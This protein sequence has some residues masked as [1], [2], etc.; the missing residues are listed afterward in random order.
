[1]ENVKIKYVAVT[2]LKSH[3]RNPRKHSKK[4]VRQIGRSIKRFGFVGVIIV[5][6]N[7]CII[8]GHARVEAAKALGIKEVPVICVDHL[9]EEELLAY[10]VA[11]NKL[12][13]NAEW[14]F[15]LLG[16]IFHILDVSGIDFDLEITGFDAPEIDFLIDQHAGVADEEPPDEIPLPPDAGP[17]VSRRN[18]LWLL[19]RHRLL[20]DDATSPVSYAALMNGKKAQ[21]V[22]TDPPYNVRIGGHVSG[23]GRH[24]HDEFVMA[25]GEMSDAEYIVFLETV[26]R[27]MA[28]NSV[29]G[30]VHDICIDWRHVHDLLT[31]GRAVYQKLL[32]IAVWAKPNAGMGS[33]YRS[34]HELVAIFKNGTGKHINN[35]ELGRHGRNRSNLWQ[36]AGMSSFGA[37]RDDLLSLHPTVKPLE[38]VKDAVLDCSSRGGIVL[39][40][41][42]GSGTTMLAAEQTGRKACA[43]ELDPKYID[44]AIRRWQALTGQVAELAETCQ[45]F[46]EVC[47][48]RSEASADHTSEAAE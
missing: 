1:M 48:E 7:N 31:A 10:M 25:S 26:L 4:Q 27:L 37:D 2:K 46:D 19:G 15:P 30:S 24:Q 14:G 29:N 43:M 12:T 18:D 3:P 33:L 42:A 38:L 35:V 20:C 22:F 36:Y 17:A 32:N 21:F 40:P 47:A 39:D 11:D 13:E 41:F 5:D 9:C 6:A 34:Q 28:A 44:V 16:E 45:T 23:K 8:A